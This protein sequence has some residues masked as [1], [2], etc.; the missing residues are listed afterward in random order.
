[1]IKEVI[2]T[3][4]KNSMIQKKDR[5]VVAVSGGPDSMCLL[6]LLYRLREKFDISICAAHVNHCLRGKAADEDE[7]FVRKF[8]EKSGI[9][10]YV[11]RVDVNKI[12]HE[13][14]ISSELAG[15]EARY[16][17]FEEVRKK[18]KAN[19]I[20]IAHNANDQAETILMRIIRGTGTE[21]IKGIRPV[22]DGYYIRPLIETKRSLIE[23]YCKD[24][25][26]MPRIDC[27]N[28]QRDYSRN[29]IRLDLI[30]YIVKNFNEDVV[31]SLDRLG[32]L[33]TIDDNYL[34][35][36]AES[37]YK[38]YCNE[39]EKKV[40][41]T[42][43]AFLNDMAILSRIIR[44]AVLHLAK[45]TY[46]LE[47]KH[48]DSIVEC[49]KNET[50]KKIDLPLN[51]RA[52]NDYGNICLKLKCD[53]T[54]KNQNE[55]ELN[56]GHENFIPQENLS[57]M[58]K[59][60]HDTKDINLK[61]NK[62]IK[63]FDA[64]KAGDNIIVRYRANGDKFMPLG[65]KNNKKLKDIFIDLKIP[66]EERKKIPL[67]CFGGEIAWIT[68]FKISEKFKINKNTKKILEIKIEREE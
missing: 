32:E 45:S 24:E 57:I 43:E 58:I 38:L 40:I 54:H 28:L 18:F 31:G 42:K 16:N 12:A 23:K 25:R 61:E 51:I 63:Y 19:K 34:E 50:G 35:K 20:A 1:M 9:Q 48:I 56:I 6:H 53:E 39:C 59:L 27:T 21:G 4:K 37:K 36:V 66:R 17:F 14:K 67:I 10:F 2:N 65:M 22:R 64:D 30:P 11:K 29:K 68:G 5:I 3:I 41:I 7:E 26:L 46:N 47:K 15:R 52:Y 62:Y 8:C 60:I 55:Y 33:V 49:Q 44:M 13:K